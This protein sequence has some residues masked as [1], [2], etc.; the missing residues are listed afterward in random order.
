MRGKSLLMSDFFKWTLVVSVVFHL[1]VVLGISFVMPAQAER[2]VFGPPLKITLVTSMSETPPDRTDT[3]AQVNSQG[4]DEAFTEPPGFENFNEVVA[5]TESQ[6]V[7]NQADHVIS[8]NSVDGTIAD[9]I[10]SQTLQASQDTV[11]REQLA[12]NINIAYLN[13][14]AQPREKY[15]SARTRESKY[16]AYIEK[17]RLL[18]ERV[19]NLNYPEQAKRQK[20]KGSLVL[21]VAISA[22]GSISNIRILDSSGIKILDD[23]AERILHIA[24]PFDRF[25]ESIKA[26][27][28]TLHIVRTWEF[29]QNKMK[30]LNVNL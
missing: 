18:V 13:S 17:W 29:G 9:N 11:T 16:A 20:L 7:A 23:A 21:D 15:V 26:E 30:S 24:A 22:D 27:V 14:Q 25:P 2:P 6:S 28:D 10:S 4:E 19:G 12:E 3:L 8:D 1:F 5:A